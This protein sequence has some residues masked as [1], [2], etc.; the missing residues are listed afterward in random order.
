MTTCIDC[1]QEMTTSLGCTI[2]E[3]TLDGVVYQRQFFGEER[4]WRLNS[5]RCGDCGATNGHHHHL[6]CD[7]ARCPACGGQLLSCGCPFE[8]YGPEELKMLA[9][10]SW[11]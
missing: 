4:G 1:K 6:G 8:E 2:T 10:D 11:M 9:E 3:L 5:A 7:I